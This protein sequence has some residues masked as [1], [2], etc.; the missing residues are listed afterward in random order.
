MLGRGRQQSLKGGEYYNRAGIKR[1]KG[2]KLGTMG[3]RSGKK[4]GRPGCGFAN[5]TCD[6]VQ[7]GEKKA[8]RTKNTTGGKQKRW[9]AFEKK[10]QV[11]D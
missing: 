11:G 2:T 6:L 7:L 10:R 3:R 1:R 9:F 4:K 5:R 8:R